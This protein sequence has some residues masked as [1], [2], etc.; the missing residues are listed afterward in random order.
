SLG[1]KSGC[2][3]PHRPDDGGGGVVSVERCTSCLAPRLLGSE[4]AAQLGALDYEMLVVIVEH[5]GDGAPACPAC[6]D[7][8]LL[9]SRPPLLVAASVQHVE[10][11]EV[12]P[13]LGEQTRGGEVVLTCGPESR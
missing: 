12:G 11:G 10:R 1:T 13:Q 6:E 7:R 8:L 3:S 9:G 2:G 4:K 5:L